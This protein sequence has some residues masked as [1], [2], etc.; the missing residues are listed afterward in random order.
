MTLIEL[1]IAMSL[2]LL[3]LGSTLAVFTTMERDSSRS[4]NQLDAQGE[5]RVASEIL[6]LRLRNLAAP[7]A[8]SVITI[9]PG[10]SIERATAQDLVFRSI[11]ATGTPSAL[12]PTNVQRDRFCVTGTRLY[13]Q[14]Q[15]WTTADPGMP[16][17]TC[18]VATG[19]TTTRVLAQHVTNGARPAFSYLSNP[20]GTVSEASTVDTTDVSAV[21]SVQSIRS[22]L[23]VDAK[24]NVAPREAELTSRIF[25]RNQNRKPTA[26]F[27]VTCTGVGRGVV[28]N[29]S[30]SS[31]PEGGP[32][33]FEWQDG[34]VAIP[35]ATSVVYTALSLS[36]GTHSFRLKATD[37][38]NQSTF[39]STK[40]ATITS[41][42]SVP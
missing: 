38:S 35:N 1:L 17:G 20:S 40:T 37:N 13:R 24:P 18:G 42:C 30:D 26:D 36:A 9:D 7:T 6:A 34:G 2:S 3:L 8:G 27:T 21:Q 16:A 12:N 4:Q 28:L 29:G 5:A 10:K 19:W 33:T 41:T 39:S 31:D 25:L 23:F 15:T 11:S 32:L 14:T 22:D